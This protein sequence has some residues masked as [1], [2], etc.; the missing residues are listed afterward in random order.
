[1]RG[2]S[3]VGIVA[4]SFTSVSIEPPLVSVCVAKTSTT[5]PTLSTASRLG[6]SVLGEGQLDIARALSGREPDRFAGI[7]W[8]RSSAGAVFMPGA[9]LWLDCA[10][11]ASFEAG[12]HTIALLR[13]EALDLPDDVAPLVFHGSRY[14]QLVPAS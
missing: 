12:D 10:I 1:M 9:C 13:I 8:T 14:R 6:V 3:P 2:E 5:W 4:S 11:Y 7:Q